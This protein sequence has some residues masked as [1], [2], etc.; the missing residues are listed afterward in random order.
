MMGDEINNKKFRVFA[1]RHES[2]QQRTV[3]SR[4]FPG[5]GLGEEEE[6][7]VVWDEKGKTRSKK[8]REKNMLG[9]I[10]GNIFCGRV[11]CWE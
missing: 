2:K 5:C 6:T 8:H 9:I 1:R 3:E 10:C 11:F 4:V 7:R